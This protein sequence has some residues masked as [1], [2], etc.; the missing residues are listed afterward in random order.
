MSKITIVKELINEALA[1]I[2]KSEAEYG[3][4]YVLNDISRELGEELVD[5]VGWTL[6]QAARLKE[7]MLPA[8]RRLDTSFFDKF[9]TRQDTSF[10]E[11]LKEKV[12]EELE[13]RRSQEFKPERAVVIISGGLD[14]TVL[15]HY[16]ARSLKVKDIYAL[17]F[18][19]GQ[20]HSREVE[21]AKYQA[22]VVGCKEHKIVDISTISSLLTKSSLIDKSKPLSTGEYSYEIAKT[23]YVPN[24]NMILLSI[25]VGWAENL[26]CNVVYYGA[27]ATDASSVYLDCREEFIKA[28]SE[29]SSL[30][31][32]NKVRIE[33]PFAR[34][35]KKDIVRIGAD[36]GVDFSKT[37]SCYA[38][39]E[40]PCQKCPTCLERLSAFKA[41]DIIDPLNV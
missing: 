1:K 40:K 39:E 21:C 33:A 30:A 34:L 8:M 23:T 24:R 27:H 26:D 11:Y 17:T 28:V 18:I 37:W 3:D 15:L 9:F 25:A 2:E 22:S 32:Y 20:R 36:L 38:G 10:L 13:K 6:M 7:I 35:Q 41:N 5:I 12:S 16:V 4:S 19:Y 14:S 29:A 31:T